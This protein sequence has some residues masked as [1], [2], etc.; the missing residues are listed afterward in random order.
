MVI[1]SPGAPSKLYNW[2]KCPARWGALQS[3]VRRESLT[4]TSGATAT[5]AHGR[6]WSSM[7]SGTGLFAAPSADSITVSR[8]TPMPSVAG[9]STIVTVPGA[10]PLIGLT[11]TQALPSA[12][13]VHESTPWP[14]LL[15]AT[16]QDRRAA[17]PTAAE[18]TTAAGDTA[19]L[20]SGGGGFVRSPTLQVPVTRVRAQTNAPAAHRTRTGVRSVSISP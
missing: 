1:E 16:V 8:Y 10:V 13:A 6:T 18:S 4:S 3:L 11:T 19:S 15:I 7:A 14:A 17:L 2:A 5:V 9:S 12:C 20:P